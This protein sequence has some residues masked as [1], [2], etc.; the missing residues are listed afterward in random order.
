MWVRALFFPARFRDSV[1]SGPKRLRRTKQSS[2]YAYSNKI[3][4]RPKM[5]VDTQVNNRES[6]IGL[7]TYVRLVIILD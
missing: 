3:T 5:C 6:A 2:T 7:K 1:P 4:Q